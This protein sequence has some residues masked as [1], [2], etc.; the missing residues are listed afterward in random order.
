MLSIVPWLTNY[1]TGLHKLI[2]LRIEK[3]IQFR[4]QE[5]KFNVQIK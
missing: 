5:W 3:K 4:T 2:S 1:I